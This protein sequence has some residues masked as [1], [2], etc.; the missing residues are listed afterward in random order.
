MEYKFNVEEQ[1][2]RCIEWTRDHVNA[3]SPN[4]VAVIGISGGKDSTC[5]AA[6]LSEAL[7]KDRVLGLL[8]P[9]GKQVDIADSRQLVEHLGIPHMEINIADSV[10]GLT[11]E[12]A[13]Q[14]PGQ[15]L[16]QGYLTNTPAR[17]RMTTLFGVAAQIGNGLVVNTCNRSED[18]VGYATIFGDAAGTFS[19]I[20]RM[21]TEEVI[22]VGDYLGLPGS[23]THK[24]PTDGMSLNADGTLMGDEVKLG[25]SY[26]EINTIIR[27][28]E[29]TENY[30]KIVSM[31][32]RSRFK[33]DIV[34]MPC[35]EPGLYDYFLENFGI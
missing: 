20:C 10:D 33:L 27:T 1:A 14:F 7:G 4:A 15:E 21:T 22:A 30:D 31:Y 18:V 12:I 8:L 26:H 28:G 16:N 17:I 19:P 11:A 3:I 25:V 35:Y 2:A 5:C 6:I 32:K 24:L 13:R 34:H 29:K 23:L 9:N